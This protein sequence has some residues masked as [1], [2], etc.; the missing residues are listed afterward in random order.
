[1]AI[2]NVTEMVSQIMTATGEQARGSEQI[3]KV[4]EIFKEI[5]QKNLD[6]VGEMDRALSLLMEQTSIL[7]REISIFKT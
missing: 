7:K 2:E 4:V 6:S 5:N 3:V 1:M